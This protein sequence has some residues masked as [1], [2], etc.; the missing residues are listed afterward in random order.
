VDTL[1]YS[2]ST[3]NSIE[4]FYKKEHWIE[5]D[6][7][8]LAGI[9]LYMTFAAIAILGI[10][11]KLLLVRHEKKQMMNALTGNTFFVFSSLGNQ[12]SS[13]VNGIFCP[14]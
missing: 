14:D 11:I 6:S 7:S 9:I 2:S 5:K 4:S 8:K 13:T 3:M 10:V 1:S 12:S